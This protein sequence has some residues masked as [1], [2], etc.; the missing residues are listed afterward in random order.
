MTRSVGKSFKGLRIGAVILA[1]FCM[2]PGNA[3]TFAAERAVPRLQDILPRMDAASIVDQLNYLRLDDDSELYTEWIDGLSAAIATAPAGSKLAL[4]AA[5]ILSTIEQPWQ[6]SDPKAA[7]RAV[8]K[9]LAA[10]DV[11][12]DQI[13]ILEKALANEAGLYYGAL[14]EDTSEPA[15]VR[16]A[17]EK[18]DAMAGFPRN[19]YSL[20]SRV[21]SASLLLKCHI[22]K[23][24]G[25][26]VDTPLSLPN[27]LGRALETTEFLA[28]ALTIL[29]GLKPLD[30]T[31]DV[32]RAGLGNWRWRNDAVFGLG[33]MH[34]YGNDK[35]A[36]AQHFTKLRDWPAALSEFK[37]DIPAQSARAIRRI[38]SD[39]IDQVYMTSAAPG[40]DAERN[41]HFSSRVVGKHMIDFLESNGDLDFSNAE[42]IKKL[43]E[44]MGSMQ[45]DD[46]TIIFGSFKSRNAANRFLQE[47]NSKIAAKLSDPKT[48]SQLAL[49]VGSPK[50]RSL[51][52]SVRTKTRLKDSEVGS[53]LQA[54][55]DADVSSVRPFPYRPQVQ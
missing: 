55:E 42:N 36:A 40:I 25:P 10:P 22:T 1:V 11:P 15:G 13:L 32:F 46:N 45:N 34:L 7:R 33:L 6:A 30:P 12:N 37:A 43:A 47:L 3:E 4:K 38:E 31:S 27:L 54:F 18:F 50:G 41:R 44:H 24:C 35:A 26:V 29:Q 8:S 16:R 19:T 28:A 49:E 17:L 20:I 51:W 5:R 21:Q 48:R 23:I 9:A 14:L 53:A 39:Y 52:Y 2:M